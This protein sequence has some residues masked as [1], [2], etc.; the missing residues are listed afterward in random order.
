MP[1]SQVIRK[2][3]FQSEGAGSINRTRELFRER[4]CDEDGN[5]F[6]IVV[7]CGSS[8]SSRTFYTLDDGTPVAFKS[9]SVFKVMPTGKLLFPCED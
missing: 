6:T 7:W 5:V 2:S 3:R 8:R 9:H 1:I 4:W